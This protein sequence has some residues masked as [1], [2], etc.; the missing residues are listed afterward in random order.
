MMSCL[1]HAACMKPELVNDLNT[2]PQPRP[3]SGSTPPGHDFNIEDYTREE[4]EQS[5]TPIKDSNFQR[6]DEGTLWQRSVRFN[7][8]A[9]ETKVPPPPPGDSNLDNIVQ[10]GSPDVTKGM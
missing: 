6:I 8:T 2:E 5:K 9:K 4:A 1:G 3:D 7:I 10:K